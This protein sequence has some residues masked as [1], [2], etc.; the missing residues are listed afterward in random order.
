MSTVYQSVQVAATRAVAPE[1]VHRAGPADARISEMGWLVV[2]V[3][4]G[5]WWLFLVSTLTLGDLM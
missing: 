3:A 4:S 2:L 1:F 5:S